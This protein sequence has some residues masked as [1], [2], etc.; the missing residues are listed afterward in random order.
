MPPFSSVAPAPATSCARSWSGTPSRTSL[1]ASVNSAAHH[2]QI[3]RAE[4]VGADDAVGRLRPR[5]LIR[6]RGSA[7]ALD[8]VPLV[9][10]A[11]R[12]R[13]RHADR[14]DAR[15]RA[16]PRQHLAIARPPARL[17]VLHERRIGG[18]EQLPVVAEADSPTP[19][20]AR[21]AQSHPPRGASATARSGRRPSRCAREPA[22]EHRRSVRRQRLQIR[23]QI[24]LR[25]LERR[26]EAGY[27]RRDHR[28][29]GWSPP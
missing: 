9:E 8:R 26:P 14:G 25:Q 7:D 10:I 15:Q 3:Q 19:P 18:D 20:S 5:R 23:H 12:H 1:P 11:E 6:T 22:P 29:R 2:R 16:H 21:R 28:E 13:R 17:V 4:V 27:H 24:G